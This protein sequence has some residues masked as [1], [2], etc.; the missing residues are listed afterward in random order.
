MSTALLVARLLLA[1]AFLALSAWFVALRRARPDLMSGW[2]TLEIVVLFLAMMVAALAA[3]LGSPPVALG[4][5]TIADAVAWFLAVRLWAE[6]RP[7]PLSEE[8]AT[9][10]AARLAHAALDVADAA[11]RRRGPRA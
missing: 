2:M 5:L 4:C 3:G 8:E 7:V 10:E 1:P 9:R 6:R 11:E